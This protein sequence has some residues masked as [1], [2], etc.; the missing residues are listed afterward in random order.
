MPEKQTKQM[1]VI[2]VDIFNIINHMKNALHGR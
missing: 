1:N 2:R